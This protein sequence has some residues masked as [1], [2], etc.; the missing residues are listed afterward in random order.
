LRGSDGVG[1]GGAADDAAATISAIGAMLGKTM[2][3]GLASPLLVTVPAST[4]ASTVEVRLCSALPRTSRASAG[5]PPP[6]QPI[7]STGAKVPPFGLGMVKVS[8]PC[9]RRFTDAVRCSSSF[10]FHS[11]HH[12]GCDEASHRRDVIFFGLKDALRQAPWSSVAGVAGRAT[13]SLRLSVRSHTN[14]KSLASIDAPFSDDVV[15]GA[16]VIV[17]LPMGG[18]DVGEGH[19]FPQ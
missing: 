4:V 3:R 10:P 15:R 7:P 14:T 11:A 18:V 1:G 17:H 8:V 16:A 2:G 19:A 9:S 5:S 13:N 12:R 6:S